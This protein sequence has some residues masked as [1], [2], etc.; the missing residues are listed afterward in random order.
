[1]AA[2]MTATTIALIGSSR[3]GGSNGR[4]FLC[5]RSSR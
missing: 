2:A 3:R 4:G 5:R 1:M